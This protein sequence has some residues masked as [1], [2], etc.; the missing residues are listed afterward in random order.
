MANLECF[1]EKTPFSP[2]GVKWYQKPFQCIQL[3]VYARLI[4]NIFKFLYL[5]P[6]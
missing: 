3:L 1:L 2:L 4:C 6:Y 5:L